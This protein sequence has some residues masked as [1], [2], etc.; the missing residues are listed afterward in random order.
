MNGVHIQM[1]TSSTEAMAQDRSPRKLMLVPNSRCT[2]WL[3]TPK[4]GS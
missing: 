4:V 1:S 2:R 3:A